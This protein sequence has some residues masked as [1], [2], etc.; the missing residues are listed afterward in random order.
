MTDPMSVEQEHFRPHI[1]AAEGLL[2][3]RAFPEGQEPGN[4][5]KIDRTARRGYGLQTEPWIGEHRDG[6]TPQSR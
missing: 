1:E 6:A 4:I 5:G 3:E 2:D